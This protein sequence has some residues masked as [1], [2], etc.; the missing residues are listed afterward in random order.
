MD[1]R[2][3]KDR[4]DNSIPE[5][6]SLFVYGRRKNIRRKEDKYKFFFFDQYNSKL[7]IAMVVLLFLSLV[8]AML[9]LFLID[10]GASE[11]NPVMA[12]FLK[13][14]PYTFLGVK[15]FIT[16]YAALILLIF[17]NFFIRKLKIFTRALF[18]YAIGAFIVVIGWEVFLSYRLL[19]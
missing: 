14:G 2:S 3:G 5:V 9:T 12:Y 17:Q 1:R 4:R 19:N 6:K 8:D 18:R 11:I 7:I 16:C 15:Y 13:F 10:N